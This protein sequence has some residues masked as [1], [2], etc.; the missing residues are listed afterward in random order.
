MYIH[1]TFY[2]P[3]FFVCA[4]FLQVFEDL[5]RMCRN[6]FSISGGQKMSKRE[7]QRKNATVRK[8]IPEL[9]LSV[10]ITGDA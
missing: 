5:D 1:H 9:Q 8:Q 6:K 4:I 10:T 3:C 7:Q 2:I